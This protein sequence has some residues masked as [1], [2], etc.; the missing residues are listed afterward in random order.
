M[1]FFTHVSHRSPIILWP[2]QNCCRPLSLQKH[3]HTCS[4]ATGS[5]HM[6]K[7]HVTKRFVAMFF[8]N[9][10]NVHACSLKKLASCL[11]P[12]RLRWYVLI[13]PM[14]N[15]NI[16]RARDQSL[17]SP[18]QFSFP[19]SRGMCWTKWRIRLF[20]HDART[21]SDGQ[22]KLNTICQICNGR[23]KIGP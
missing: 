15:E 13:I 8:S 11:L 21:R 4:S 20:S 1:C 19:S 10:E 18:C 23:E 14:P 3:T 16:T 5:S 6:G 2:L 9:T 17:C 7:M 12:N 22:R